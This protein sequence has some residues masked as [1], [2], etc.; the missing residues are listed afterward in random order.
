ML[1][2]AA[3]GLS[4]VLLSA[5][6]RAPDAA[7]QTAAHP[8]STAAAPTT[9]P[10]RGSAPVAGVADAYAGKGYAAVRQSLLGDGWLPLRTAACRTNVG[11]E[12]TV[13]NVLPETD[14]CSGDGHCLMRFANLA[15]PRV[16]TL[17]AYGDALRWNDPQGDFM[18]MSSE[19][20]PAT[21]PA[22]I[23]CPAPEFTGFLRAYAAAAPTR[24][25]FTAPIVRASEVQSDADGDRLVPVAYAAA[26]YAGFNLVHDGRAFHHIDADGHADP[27][28]LDVRVDTD[29]ASGA[30]TVRYAYGSTEGRGYRFERVGD[31]W[32][33]T[34][35]LPPPLD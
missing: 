34:E 12:A 19:V 35:Q 22:A 27:S 7:S 29:A 6:S 9:A 11:G 13:C 30:A 10:A 8:P 3:W 25:A 5:C 18:V 17:H 15:G 14:S 16:L 24:A 20:A 2:R 26:G 1:R 28:P 4:F 33:L 23:A 31:C 32:H 21:S